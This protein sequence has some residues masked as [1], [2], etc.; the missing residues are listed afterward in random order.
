MD[1]ETNKRSAECIKSTWVKD[2]QDKP[3]FTNSSAFEGITDEDYFSALSDKP[4]QME[5]PKEIPFASR[6]VAPSPTVH[7]VG[8]ANIG[9]TE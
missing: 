9:A 5:E 1:Q 7:N 2:L 3:V 4:V 6:R 8:Q